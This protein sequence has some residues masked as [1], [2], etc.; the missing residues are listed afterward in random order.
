MK[1]PDDSNIDET[2]RI[3][4]KGIDPED[5]WLLEM[6]YDEV[7]HTLT[8]VVDLSI[9]PASKYYRPPIPGEWTCYR[10]ARIHFTGIQ[11]AEGLFDLQEVPP[12]IDPNGEKDWDCIYALRLEGEMVRFTLCDREITLLAQEMQLMID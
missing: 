11:T 4:L 10:K 1:L 8:L 12:N 3:V 7:Q 9:W 5:S 6:R 2:G